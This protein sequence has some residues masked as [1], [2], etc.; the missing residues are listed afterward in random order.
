MQHILA[1]LD[2]QSTTSMN[3]TNLQLIFHNRKVYILDT[4]L[5]SHWIYRNPSSLDSLFAFV[6]ALRLT[7]FFFLKSV[8]TPDKVSVILRGYNL[9]NERSVFSL[10]TIKI[11]VNVT[12][13]FF[14]LVHISLLS[15]GWSVSNS[16]TSSYCLLIGS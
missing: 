10:N 13:F 11:A 9:G 4:Q 12:A 6:H 8:F 16:I 15:F 3:V 14:V 1:S 7:V 5:P 2:K